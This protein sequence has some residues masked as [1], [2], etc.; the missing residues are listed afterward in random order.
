MS[1]S[2]AAIL[3]CLFLLPAAWGASIPPLGGH[4]LVLAFGDSITHGTGAGKGAS[5]P[6]R[7]GAALGVP[8]INAGVPGEV[9][10]EGKKRLPAFLE[11][12]RPTLVILCHGGNDLIQG[13]P[14][15]EIARDLEEMAEAVKK[16]ASDLVIVGVPEPG[17]RLSVPS[18][19]G[20]VAEGAGALYEGRILRR[21]LSD[22]SLKS[23]I[24]HPNEAGYLLLAEKLASLIE[25]AQW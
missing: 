12:H 5:Y 21:I 17:P 20:D 18:F 9:V 7:L 14:H 16:S 4:S 2:G 11:K 8:V 23:D 15:G 24:I 19:Y 1:R 3:F 10:S 6:D 25:K 22:P 13:K